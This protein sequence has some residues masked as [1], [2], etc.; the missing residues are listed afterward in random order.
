MNKYYKSE[1]IYNVMVDILKSIGVNTE[2]SHIIASCYIEADLAGVKTHGTNIFPAHIEK[3]LNNTYKKQ[4]KIEAIQQGISFE[5][6]EGDSSIGPVAAYKA[7]SIAIEKAKETGIFTCFLKNTNTIGPA[8][9]YNNIALENK[10]I[11]ITISNS[12][13]QMAPTNGKD[14]LIGTNPIAISI[15]ANKENPIIY[16]IATS[17]VAK[18]KIKQALVEGKEIPEDWATDI[19]GKSTTNPEEAIKGLVLPMSGYKG[20]GLAIIVDIL[21]GVISGSSF[22]NNVGRFYNND[23]CMNVGC[24][25]IAINPNIIMGNEFYNKV[26]EYICTI[27]NSARVNENIPIILP[28]ENR[29]NNK[30][31]NK[32]S[33]IELNQETIE[34]INKYIN[35]Y[36]L[37]YKL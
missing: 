5:V 26:D 14:K 29:I 35:I 20:Y 10:M 24:T 23:K 1:Q 27:K 11:G 8:F 2:D 30:K 36:N 37:Q 33:G 15:P 12:P 6:I 28:G 18:S 16:D 32:E 3:F 34:A 19:N 9:F 13:A 7:M 25:F 17:Q 4:P 22:L 21:S 31:L